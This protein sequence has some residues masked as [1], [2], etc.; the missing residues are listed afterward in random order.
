M[1]RDLY[2][3]YP[4]PQ[5]ATSELPDLAKLGITMQD[6]VGSWCAWP[7]EDGTLWK[8]IGL[9]IVW[10][11]NGTIDIRPYDGIDESDRTTLIGAAWEAW[12]T[13]PDPNEQWEHRISQGGRGYWNGTISA[14]VNIGDPVA[15]M[16][17]SA[18][19]FR[20]RQDRLLDQGFDAA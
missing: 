11:D 3:Q 17:R 15:E 1:K 2:K 13:P 7:D 20:E 10:D 14:R 4:C 8:E 19:N 16:L 5:I 12:F 9:I 6:P 18:E